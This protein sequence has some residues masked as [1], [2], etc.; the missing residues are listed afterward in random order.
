MTWAKLDLCVRSSS[1]TGALTNSPEAEALRTGLAT[2]CSDPTYAKGLVFY[3]DCRFKD[4][5]LNALAGDPPATVQHGLHNHW[6]A[7]AWVNYFKGAPL[8]MSHSMM[9]SN[10]LRSIH[11][12]SDEPVVMLVVGTER[13]SVDWDPG[14]FDRLIVFHVD[15]IEVMTGGKQISFNF[16]KLRAML[17]PIK[18]L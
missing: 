14:I 17:L 6:I 7:R 9:G 10:L 15:P 1:G 11:M 18:V 16:N 3:L 12:F 2:L 8:G 4:A 5:Y 13:L